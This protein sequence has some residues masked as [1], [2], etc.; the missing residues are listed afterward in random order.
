M[1]LSI[2]VPQFACQMAENTTEGA[3]PL[4][5]WSIPL[6]GQLLLQ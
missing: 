4:S 2:A 5:E 6:C 3:L 1:V